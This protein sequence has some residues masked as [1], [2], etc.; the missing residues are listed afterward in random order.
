MVIEDDST[1]QL[2][3]HVLRHQLWKLGIA[4]RIEQASVAEQFARIQERTYQ[5]AVDP[6][7][8][9]NRRYTSS[10]T[11]V[12]GYDNPD[13]SAA[14]ARSDFAGAQAILD[15]DVPFTPLYDYRTF[16]AIDASFC[17]D[18]TPSVTSWRWIADLYPCEDEP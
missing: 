16:A 9:G 14:V 18:V 4:L 15:R 5:L 7:P 10:A 11:W 2:T 17:G 13:Y 6:L 8:K 3:A 1:F 12:S